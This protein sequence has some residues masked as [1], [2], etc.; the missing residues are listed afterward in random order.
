MH[1]RARVGVVAKLTGTFFPSSSSWPTDEMDGWIGCR[2]REN[3]TR[4]ARR[5]GVRRL[6]RWVRCAHADATAVAVRRRRRRGVRRRGRRERRGRVRAAGAER[7][8]VRGAERGG[9]RRVGV[10]RGVRAGRGRGVRA[11]AAAGGVRRGESWG[12]CVAIAQSIRD[13]G[14]DF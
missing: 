13:C 8:G 5:D 14:D 3:A 2:A 7:W 12:R 6:V 11:A 1:D 10:G 9:V 4:D